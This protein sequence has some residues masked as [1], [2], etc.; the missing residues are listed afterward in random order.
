MYSLSH[1]WT[2]T[3]TRTHSNYSDTF[4]GLHSKQRA[5]THSLQR[6]EVICWFLTTTTTHTHT[7]T[8]THTVKH[9]PN[10]IPQPQNPHTRT[11]RQPDSVPE[12]DR[13]KERGEGIREGWEGRK[14]GYRTNLSEKNT[15]R[16][17]EEGEEEEAP[18]SPAS[19]PPP[20][21]RRRR[22]RKTECW[23]ENKSKVPAWVHVDLTYMP[24]QHLP[25]HTDST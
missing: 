18:L 25:A 11:E 24:T 7:H 5:N 22:R 16:G 9:T 21:L 13:Q 20:L 2:H 17:E 14:R 23:Q 4:T 19:S 6:G 12:Y 3:Y 15:E 1:S 10:N 8:H